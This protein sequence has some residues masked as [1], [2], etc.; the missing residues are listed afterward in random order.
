[1]QTFRKALIGVTA[2]LALAAGIVGT[3]AGSASMRRMEAVHWGLKA[4]TLPDGTRVSITKGTPDEGGERAIEW[5]VDTFRT[6]GLRVAISPQ[7][8]RLPALRHPRGTCPHRTAVPAD[9]SRPGLA[10]RQS[11]PPSQPE[12]PTPGCA[13]LRAFGGLLLGL[14]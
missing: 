4:D 11:L 14:R 5:C 1:M 8:P 9:R 10:T 13:D 7:R 6:D 3:T 2:S 12:G